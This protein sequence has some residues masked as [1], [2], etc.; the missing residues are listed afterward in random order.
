M[1]FRVLTGI[2]VLVTLLAVQEAAA[3]APTT[4]K[5]DSGQGQ[6]PTKQAKI[7]LE[8]VN[9][10]TDTLAVTDWLRTLTIDG[11]VQ[12]TVG[13]ALTR[14]STTMGQIVW[15]SGG[16]LPGNHTVQV[17][18]KLASGGTATMKVTTIMFAN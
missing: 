16:P 6:T 7:V 15:T 10:G 4:V 17:T 18:V 12:N 5:V 8:L 11:A 14:G 13:I 1:R 3:D 9:P 2:G